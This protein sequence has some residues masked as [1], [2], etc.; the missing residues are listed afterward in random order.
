[1]H[2][3]QQMEG[4]ECG[5]VFPAAAQSGNAVFEDALHLHGVERAAHVGE[6]L[7][8]QGAGGVLMAHGLLSGGVSFRPNGGEAGRAHGKRATG[9]PCQTPAV[10]AGKMASLR[11]TVERRE[12]GRTPRGRERHG[13]HAEREEPGGIGFSQPG[14]LPGQ[15]DF[16]TK[17]GNG[18]LEGF[19]ETG[20][21][22]VSEK[23]LAIGE[24]A[25]RYERRPVQYE[26]R[27]APQPV[28][29]SGQSGVFPFG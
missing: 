18:Q 14:H 28:G 3:L 1:M 12:Q 7:A 23:G 15:G 24:K 11:R 16:L 6:R 2:V 25:I 22:A 13:C 8:E 10:F 9:G 20:G 5:V 26:G 19:G 27:F 4:R 29:E 17:H 21:R